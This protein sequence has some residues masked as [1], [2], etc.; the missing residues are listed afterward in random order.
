MYAC[1]AGW[2]ATFIG[3]EKAWFAG[4]QPFLIGDAVKVVI[5]ALLAQTAWRQ[6][7]R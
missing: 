5:A 6:A 7:M 1:G 2:L 4:V 3:V